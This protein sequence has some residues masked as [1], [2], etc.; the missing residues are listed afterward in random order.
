V[1]IHCAPLRIVDLLL[2]SEYSTKAGEEK[3]SMTTI[4]KQVLSR[5]S[6]LRAAGSLGAGAL[7]AACAAPSGSAPSESSGESAAPSTEGKVIKF[8]V[9]WGSPGAIADQLLAD[10]E[11]ENYIGAGNSIDWDLGQLSGLYVARGGDPIG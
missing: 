6:F 1:R 2:K 11:L 9:F 7:L 5:R 10:P 4:S 8:Y 3:P